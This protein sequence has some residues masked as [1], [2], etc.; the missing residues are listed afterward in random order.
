MNYVGAKIHHPTKP[1]LKRRRRGTLSSRGSVQEDNGH[2]LLHSYHG[3]KSTISHS[4]R[5]LYSSIKHHIQSFSSDCIYQYDLDT[6]QMNCLE[7]IKE[8]GMS[9]QLDNHIVSPM[10]EECTLHQF[11]PLLLPNTQLSWLILLC[12]EEAILAYRLPHSCPDI[13]EATRLSLQTTFCLHMR[14]V[15]EGNP[16]YLKLLQ[17]PDSFEC[18]ELKSSVFCVST[19]LIISARTTKQWYFMI[20]RQCSLLRCSSAVVGRWG[21][22]VTLLGSWKPSVHA[23]YCSVDVLMRTSREALNWGKSTS[24]RFSTLLR[25]T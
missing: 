1:Q 25:C 6:S 23:Q 19:V 21:C 10:I 14:S 22:H 5:K 8:L 20:S 4:H 13:F 3:Y 12:G 9:L 15:L 16:N 7:S 11:S 2:H 24:P 18:T 17:L